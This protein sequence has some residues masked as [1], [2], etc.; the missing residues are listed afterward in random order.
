MRNL[1][2]IRTKQAALVLIFSVLVSYAAA[3]S[4]IRLLNAGGVQMNLNKELDALQSNSILIDFGAPTGEE[5]SVGCSKIGGKPDLPA[6]FN[7]YHFEG[8]SYDGLEENRPL[9]FL[10][11][12]NC[13][14]AKKYDKDDL[15][16]P[17]GMLYFFYE[18][19]S[20]TWGFDPKDKGS[21]RVFYFPGNTSDLQRT[22]FPGNLAEEYKLPEMAISFSGQKDW[23][24]YEEFI[25]WHNEAINIDWDKY[26][27]VKKS[28]GAEEVETISKLLGYADLIQGGMLLECEEVTNGVYTGSSVEIAADKLKKYKENCVQWQLLFQMDSIQNSDFELLWGDVGRI[29]FYIREDDLKNLSFD[30]CWLILQCG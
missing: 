28:K 27:K 5:L 24:D 23:P 6:D 16:P 29:Y 30:N 3:C 20:M 14:E 12:I 2:R 4:P 22:D 21:A 7:W 9:S 26:D 15:L 25:E 11:Q 10:A 8:E 17:K 13:E 1:L 18:L 19:A